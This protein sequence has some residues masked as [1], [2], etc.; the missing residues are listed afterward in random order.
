MSE[1]TEG[2]YHPAMDR[3]SVKFGPEHDQV[4]FSS[5]ETVDTE[6]ALMNIAFNQSVSSQQACIEETWSL[7]TERDELKVH[8]RELEAE[9][10]ARKKAL[11]EQKRWLDSIWATFTAIHVGYGKEDMTDEEAVEAMACAG[12]DQCV[13]AIKAINVALEAILP[14]GGA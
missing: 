1:Q 12:Q 9:L 4:K 3:L 6:C 11:E 13:E 14:K 5:P 2:P 7:G 10:E 8:I